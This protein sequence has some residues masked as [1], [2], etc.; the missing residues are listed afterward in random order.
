MPWLQPAP[1]AYQ[2][3][4]RVPIA[5]HTGAAPSQAASQM[6]SPLQEYAQ[7]SVARPTS[8][9]TGGHAE[10]GRQHIVPIPGPHE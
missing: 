7:P 3:S 1:G 8:S 4:E 2:P 10:N 6:R 9:Q 5:S